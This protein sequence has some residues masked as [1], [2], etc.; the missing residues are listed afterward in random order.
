MLGVDL[1]INIAD[2]SVWFPGLI[3]LGMTIGFLV[4]LFGVGGGFLL[5]PC[6]KIIFGIPYPIAVGTGLAQIFFNSSFA[7]WKHWKKKTWI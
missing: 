2:V 5:T 6:L 4:G 3:I 7:S 1:T